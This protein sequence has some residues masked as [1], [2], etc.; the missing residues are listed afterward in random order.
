MDLTEVSHLISACDSL[1]L[2][3]QYQEL[4]TK[5]S[6]LQTQLQDESVWSNPK[7][8]GSI[9][10]KLS[11]ISL[12][13]SQYDSLK[14]NLENLQIS[15]DLV[16]EDS[17]YQYQ[18]TCFKLLNEIQLI[19][20]FDGEFDS[21]GSLLSIHA[22]AGGVDAQDWAAMLMSMYQSFCKNQN[23]SCKII[24]LSI[25]EEGGVKSATLEIDSANS[26][27]LLQEEVGV[28]RLV[29]IS[30]FNSGGTRETSF[31]KVE[32]IPTGLDKN[33]D[34]GEISEDDLRWDYYLSSGKGGQSVNTTY[35]AVRLVHLPTNI[36]VTCQNERSQQQNKQHAL[37]ILKNKLAV[38]ELE[39]Q[40]KFRA[41]LRGQ[42][43]SAAWGNQIRSYVLHPYKLVKDTRSNWETADID[44]VLQSGKLLDVIWSVKK[45]RKIQEKETLSE[46]T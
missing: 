26:Y 38:I 25:G 4:K 29:R 9:N 11:N 10:Q 40:N 17:I 35:S 33:V 22:G 43:G 45:A 20:Y 16:D 42:V 37:S 7:L 28:H 46:N 34:L 30:P 1:F 13:I 12:L 19:E 18:N 24:S 39:K 23:W 36:T 3:S 32:V 41:D 21:N 5:E 31:A 6:D 14:S 27:G 44:S 8:A 2:G 15:I